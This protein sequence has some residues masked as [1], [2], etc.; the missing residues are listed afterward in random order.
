MNMLDFYEMA[1]ARA[2]PVLLSLLNRRI[3]N[4]KEEPERIEERKGI[5]ALPRPV[6]LLVHLHAASVGEAQS[7]LIVI[8]RLLKARDDIHVLVTTGTVTSARMMQNNLPPRAFHQFAP[9]DHPEW[10]R[11]FFDHWNPDLVL[12][13]ESELWPNM[14]KQ[15]QSRNI[16]V[17][18]VNARLSDKSYKR[19]TYIKGTA[20]SVLS[21]FTAVLTQTAEDA[22]R[23]ESL[24]ARNVTVMDNLKFSAKPLDFNEENFKKLSAHIGNR[25]VWLYASSHKGEEALACRVHERLK[26]TL[27]DLLTIIV[28]RH[29]VRRY[30]I[31][32]VCMKAKLKTVLRGENHISPN[33]DTDIYIADTMG[34]LGL[35]YRLAPVAVIGRCFSDDGGGGHNPIEAAQLN[36]AVLYGPHVQHQQAIFDEMLGVKAAT[37]VSTEPELVQKL[38]DFLTRPETM[39]TAQRNAMLFLQGKEKIVDRVMNAIGPFLEKKERA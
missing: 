5:S 9:L 4:G 16:P 12:W 29:P 24:G 36:C 30:E 22:R 17:M 23:F 38:H 8:Y 27:P 19:W 25:P 11:R 26:A 3:R 1:T 32:G 20:K 18:L 39:K 28:P 33:S 31:K 14:L 2:E 10:A 34:E 35:F 6:G 37:Q 7:G 13:M 15:I 21:I